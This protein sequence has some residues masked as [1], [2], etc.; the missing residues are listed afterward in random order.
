MIDAYRILG[1]EGLLDE[2]EMFEAFK[3]LI[4]EE[5]DYTIPGYTYNYLHYKPGYNIEFTYR[6]QAETSENQCEGIDIHSSG[7]GVCHLL[8]V[9]KVN[10]EGDDSFYL[11]Q[12]GDSVPFPAKI[13]CPDVLPKIIGADLFAQVVLFASYA[14]YLP[15]DGMD[16]G[17]VSNSDSTNNVVVTGVISHAEED[18]L[19]LLG[20]EI[21]FYEID[22]KT[23]LCELTAIVPISLLDK[24]PEVGDFFE[25]CGILSLDVALEPEDKANA[26]FYKDIYSEFLPEAKDRRFRFGFIPNFSNNYTVLQE[27][28]VSN[29]FASLLRCCTEIVAV[30]H[31]GENYRFREKKG[32]IDFVQEHITYSVNQATRRHLLSWKYDSL[33]GSDCIAVYDSNGLRH[34]IVLELNETGLIEQVTIIDAE[35][36]EVGMDYEQHLYYC[37]AEA[38]RTGKPTLLKE[39]LSDKCYYRSEGPD[40]ALVGRAKII[41][42]FEEIAANLTDD[43]LQYTYKAALSADELVGTDDIPDI[44]KTKR[45]VC[46]FQGGDLAAVMFIKTNSEHKITSVLLSTN[47]NY[48]KR[49]AKSTESG[50]SSTTTKDYP[51]LPQLISAIYGADNTL[52]EMR[53]QE[54]PDDDS[55]DVYVWKK[56]DEFAAQWL[57]E[58][59]YSLEKAEIEEDCIGYAC[60]RKGLKYAIFVYAYGEQKTAMLDGDYC[61]KLRDLD[62]SKDRTVLV[63]YL[64]VEKALDDAGETTYKVGR[65]NDCEQAEPW[66]LSE[67][68]GKNCLIFYPRKEM[69]D[70]VFRLAAA[71]NALNLDALK[72]IFQPGV[73]IDTYENDGRIMNDAVFSNLCFLHEN[74]GNMEIAYIRFN[75]VVYSGVPYIEGYGFFGFTVNAENRID[76]ITIRSLEETYRELLV[77]SEIIYEHETDTV[78]QLTSVEFLEPNEISRFSMRL[79]FENGER[80][81]FDIPGDHG[82][83]EVVTVDHKTFTNRIFN[84]GVIVDHI[85]LPDWFGYRN[86]PLRGQ[87]IQFIN[88][89][90]LSA[91]EL[92]HRSYPIEVFDYSQ[93]DQISFR[94]GDYSE[95]GFAVAQI[96][97]LDPADPLYLL[98]KNT[99]TARAIPQQYQMTPF[100]VYPHCGGYADGLVMVS[101]MGDIDL[102]YHHNMSGCAGLWGWLNKDLSVAIEPQF[103]FATNFYGGRA[104]V[105]RGDWTVDEDGRYWSPD[106]KWGLI[107][108]AGKEIIP[109]R[110]DEL[111]EIDDTE[112]L[113]FVHEGGWESGHYGVFD[114][115]EQKI[116]LE[117]DFDFD[118]HY[119]F[120]ECFVADGDILVFDIHLPGEGKDLIYAYDLHEQKYLAYREENTERTFQGKKTMTVTRDGEEIIIF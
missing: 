17:T 26:P 5:S 87:G 88:G 15:N 39:A 109:C 86:Y 33:S 22:I 2:A 38:M 6:Y 90:T 32:L 61:Q 56:A 98:D 7:N 64:K 78:P 101:S 65:Y 47:G 37:L 36:C 30:A 116:I 11:V 68:E 83:N 107:D 63:I 67:I 55:N 106:E 95:D 79:L 52:A 70:L 35:L 69:Y 66:L 13:V 71:Y 75:D 8:G 108:T 49:F 53:K 99:M 21:R 73:Y 89:Y 120:N 118:I 48:L 16:E 29:T 27:C 51:P 9:S 115:K 117:L 1:L 34:I 19:E 54:I 97:N 59:G 103:I 76:S 91:V 3:K 45:C 24:E 28:L 44:Y 25:F 41:S 46:L 18:T 96:E 72:A 43:S 23:D 80:K 82:T 102:Q 12:K 77:S 119:M 100:Y 40:V 113:Y 84:H 105:C 57:S 110:Y 62:L 94:G 112:R 50:K 114:V 104:I 74:K 42:R 93:Y 4:R 85:Q 31:N 20:R 81:R 58:H 14:R 10:S 60:H 92:Y 111:S